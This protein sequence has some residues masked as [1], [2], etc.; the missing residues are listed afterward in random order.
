MLPTEASQGAG[1]NAVMAT[2]PAAASAPPAFGLDLLHHGSTPQLRGGW[3]ALAP[4]LLE[5]I[6]R[7]VVYDPAALQAMRLTCTA[8]RTAIDSCVQ[9]LRVRRAHL[10]Q[11]VVQLPS[12]VHLDLSGC[13]S[14]RD[15]HLALLAASSL[16]TRLHTLKMG[17]IHIPLYPKPAISDKGL[18][19]V[20][21]M[22]QLHALALTT[23]LTITDA[24]VAALSSLTSLTSLVLLDCPQVG[25][26]GLALLDAMQGLQQLVLSGPRVT[27]AT[28]ARLPAL[29][30]L[31]SLHLC[32]TGV[33]DS[34]LQGALPRLA[35]LQELLLSWAH[36]SP[37]VLLQLCGAHATLRTLCLLECAGFTCASLLSAVARLT[38]LTR[39]HLHQV[40]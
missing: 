30:R 31:H 8:F 15:Q 5:C 3:S 7:A 12:V 1:P 24:G 37:R 36:V 21:A 2:L 28:L 6:A 26:R 22:R 25:D 32:A 29:P 23:C 19:W 34:G 35:P 39:L 17:N 20:A 13:A 38:A 40:A 9:V 18:Q 27:D 33:T 10:L 16:C 4:D 11:L 14:V